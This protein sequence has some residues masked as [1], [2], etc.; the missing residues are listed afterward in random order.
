[1]PFGQLSCH[2]WSLHVSDAF[3]KMRHAD[4]WICRPA[5]RLAL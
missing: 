1:M 2:L 4:L 3:D 5:L